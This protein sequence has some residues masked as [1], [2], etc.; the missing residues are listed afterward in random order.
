VLLRGLEDGRANFDEAIEASQ[1]AG[2]VSEFQG[3]I[4]VEGSVEKIG[5]RY[6]VTL[7]VETVAKL[8]CDRSLEEFDEPIS[9]EIQLEYIVD[10]EL[11]ASQHGTLPER[12]EVRGIMPDALAIDVTED[13][14]QELALA[15]PMKRVAPKYRNAELDEIFPDVGPKSG[16]SEDR[17]QALKKLKQK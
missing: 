8:I 3:V 10:S 7:S 2:V 1:I 9:F 15:L 5:R 13:V 16:E 12:D 14:R 4:H 6:H 17:W 11:A